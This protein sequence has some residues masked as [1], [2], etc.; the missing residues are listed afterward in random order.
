MEV[1]TFFTRLLQAP[2]PAAGPRPDALPA[3]DA[4]WSAVLTTLTAPDERQL[5][6]GIAYSPV[7]RALKHIT[8]ALVY[9]SNRTDEDTTGACLE[10]FLRHDMLAAL[11]RL[12]ERDRPRGVK[13]E[14]LRMVNNLVVLMPER[15][16]VHNAVHRPLRRL[17]RSCVGEPETLDGAARAFGAAAVDDD[18][19]YLDDD[20]VDL[21]CI[22]CSRMRAYPPLLLIFF[23]DRGW[24]IPHHSSGAPSP[25][26]FRAPLPSS[27]PQV[28][29]TLPSTPPRSSSLSPHLS[30]RALSPTPLSPPQISRALSPPLARIST[31]SGRATP[32]LY[33]EL[34]SDA[35]SAASASRRETDATHFE[36]L[37][38]S[39]LLRFVH[40]EGRIGD[41]ARAGIL[42]LFDI[43]FLS[44]D[45]E[46]GDTL[47]GTPGPDG[48]DPLQDARDALAEYILDG[49]FADVM[50]A[51]LGATYS[52]LPSKL[53]VPTL[54]EQGDEDAALNGG[55][56][57][58][59]KADEDIDDDLLLS[60]DE[61][62]R[63]Q[64]DLLLK[65]FGFLGDI[66]YRCRAASLR[67]DP[68]A[69]T[70]SIT[71]ALGPA[72]ADATLDALQTAFVDNVLYPSILECSSTDG[73]AVAV[74]TYLDVVISNLEDGPVLQRILNVLMDANAA[75]PVFASPRKR[76][77]R[78]TGAMDFM[79]AIVKPGYYTDE[80]FT[81]RDLILDNVKSWCPA[82]KAAA[83]H[84]LQALLSDHCRY[85]APSLLSL[86]RMPSATA[87]ARPSL[88]PS[89]HSSPTPSFTATLPSPLPAPVN[90]ADVHLQEDEL[91]GALVPRLDDAVQEN[92][93]ASGLGSYI[94]DAHN[95]LEADGCWR[96]SRVPLQF[97]S[98]DGKPV[99]IRVGEYDLDPYQH[100]LSPSDP[101]VHALLDA[102]AGWFTQPAD[103]NIALTGALSALVRCPHRSLAGWLLYD[104]DE[105][106]SSCEIDDSASDT[107][108]D[109]APSRGSSRDEPR[110]H[111][112][113]ALYQVLRE[114]VRHSGRF[115]AAVPGFDRLLSERRQGLLFA[116]HLEEA[117]SAMLEDVVTPP[118]AS[119]GFLGIGSFGSP[120]GDRKK[121]VSLAT[122]LRSFWSPKKS[123]PTTPVSTPPSASPLP[124]SP[125]RVP[126]PTL[127]ALPTLS[128][129][130]QRTSSLPQHDTPFASHYAAASVT[131]DVESVVRPDGW[132]RATIPEDDVFTDKFREP[133]EPKPKPEP[134]SKQK[135]TVTTLS[136]VLD[137]MIVLEEL[138][139]E[140]VG[141]IVSRR[142]LGID[143]V[144][145]VRR[146]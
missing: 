141:V 81:L 9:E 102:L 79:P 144:G 73:S 10:Y 6:R 25:A 27:P 58:G 134:E 32:G 100:A 80:R 119:P 93:E 109:A 53:R 94:M 88:P 128:S 143:Q 63:A 145:F 74:L 76:R 138:I 67:A 37:L 26:A 98:D 123:R 77:A 20:L 103:T 139:K 146:L 24:L 97:V 49:D 65:L 129:T 130:P 51:G 115:R 39:Y 47:A 89:E 35:A 96:A 42:F 34:A 124:S 136:G 78:K 50:A 104:C 107:S 142:A 135:R 8:D 55:M 19:A 7:P 122:S 11:E 84:L 54:A 16:L 116:D 36:Y 68:N 105:G 14:V 137:N 66:M 28:R 113:P 133:D 38:F 117:M 121:S 83:L 87:L 33:P 126:R 108:F 110:H 114:L 30:S 92:T 29:A 44:R 120:L 69:L 140:L 85:I 48:S 125:P 41:F 60:N 1:S 101:M 112:L 118:A 132:R 91:Y 5:A 95:F 18:P 56:I 82:S 46:G 52:L 31:P 111:T 90:S 21:M 40:R 12:C 61:D 106:M 3:F 127:P 13:A 64:L 43:A 75:V 57:L 15:F 71:E 62:V 4:A 72:V 45:D 86:V 59:T 2:K 22:L 17:L 70:V 131:V 99:L 23:H